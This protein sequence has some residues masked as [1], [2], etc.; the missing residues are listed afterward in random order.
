M[1][2]PVPRT[3]PSEPEFDGG[4]IAFFHVDW[5]DEPGSPFTP[6]L[7]QRTPELTE[8]DWRQWVGR[9]A[10]AESPVGMAKLA[11]R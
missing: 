7:T 10:E 11:D 2:E 1:G 3:W 5:H 8:F 9:R 4:T 6:V